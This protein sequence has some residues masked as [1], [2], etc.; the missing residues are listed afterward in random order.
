MSLY[1][2]KGVPVDDFHNGAGIYT[3]INTSQ[4]PKVTPTKG[5][6]AITDWDNL[7]S[8]RITATPDQIE[9][10]QQPQSSEG[11]ISASEFVLTYDLTKEEGGKNYSG[12]GPLVAYGSHN[13]WSATTFTYSDIYMYYT[14]PMLEQNDILSPLEQ[15][16]FTQKKTQ[17][18]DSTRSI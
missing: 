1:Q 13:C 18:W 10:R 3:Y 4:A 15:A 16:D 9:I 17:T 5:T 7:M 12:F 11:D 6:E 14:N 2:L 8:V